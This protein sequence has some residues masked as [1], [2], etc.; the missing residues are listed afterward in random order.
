MGV[1]NCSKLCDVIFG[2]PLSAK[3]YK[4]NNLIRCYTFYNKYNTYFFCGL[5]GTTVQVWLL[6]TYFKPKRQT[7]WTHPRSSLQKQT[8][9]AKEKV[10]QKEEE[11]PT[12]TSTTA[13]ATAAAATT[14][15]TSAATGSSDSCHSTAKQ[16]NYPRSNN[17]WKPI[18]C[19]D[20]PVAS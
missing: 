7:S 12:T 4:M 18:W 6:C 11:S 16:W 2:R 15:T 3:A 10:P 13:A 1:K 20:G 19:D 9:A 8:K 17:N 14:T 5:T